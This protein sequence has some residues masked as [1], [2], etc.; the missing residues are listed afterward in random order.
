MRADGEI[1]ESVG[2]IAYRR[3]RSDI[4]HGRLPPGE[5]LKLERLRD[6]YS[7]SIST[8]RE[9]LSR[10]ACE[11]LIVA[12][13]L[14]GFDVTPVS[15]ADLREVA[16]MRLL[17]EGHALRSS[18]AN[19]DLEWEGR[20][21]GA[22][23]K[24]AMV[25]KRMAAGGLS[26]PAQWQRYDREFHD[27]LIGACDSAALLDTHAAIADKY[28]RYQIVAAIYLGEIAAQEHGAL[29]DAALARDWPAAQAMLTDHVHRRVEE[30]LAAGKVT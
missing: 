6:D 14:R 4:L 2:E 22:H 15:A 18:L 8:L 9:L 3:I 1:R 12:E 25:E 16:A 19:G 29:L 26:E 30:A 11:G 5:K 20:V 27:A 21:V 7:A 28:A 13:G 24:L 17:L 23:H 10:L